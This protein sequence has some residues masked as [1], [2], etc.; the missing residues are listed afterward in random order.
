MDFQ[1]AAGSHYDETSC[2]LPCF[3]I[4]T[5]VLT[6]GQVS[7]SKYCTTS[8]FAPKGTSSSLFGKE[9]IWIFW[10]LFDTSRELTLLKPGDLKHNHH[11]LGRGGTC[12]FQIIN[13]KRIILDSL[14]VWY[15]ISVRMIN[16]WM[17]SFS[18]NQYSH[19]LFVYSYA[20]RICSMTVISKFGTQTF[21]QKK[22]P[23]YV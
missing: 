17:S 8:F 4:L 12:W 5:P 1:K 16:Q 18:C 3:Q 19:H 9:N 6:V 23:F 10:I 11:L 2:T 13:K 20:F 22:N 14:P 15:Q 7:R 21:T